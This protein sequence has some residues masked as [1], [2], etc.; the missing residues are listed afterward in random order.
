[1]SVVILRTG[2]GPG[3]GIEVARYEGLG[4]ELVCDFADA[5]HFVLELAGGVAEGEQEAEDGVI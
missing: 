1:M 5:G 4:L 3:V 2:V